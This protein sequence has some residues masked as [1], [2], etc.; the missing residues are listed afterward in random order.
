MKKMNP[1]NVDRAGKA[2]L[3]AVISATVYVVKK[4]GPEV[5]KQIRKS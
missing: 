5:L 1:K 2:I 3:A 4:Y